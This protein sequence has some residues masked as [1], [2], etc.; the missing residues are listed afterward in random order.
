M[1]MQKRKM[2]KK[3]TD[4]GEDED[5]DTKMGGGLDIAALEAEAAAQ[6]TQDHGSRATM[7]DRAAR[8]EKARAEER[9]RKQER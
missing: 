2:R 8:A 7:V 6:G 1:C 3:E 4:T 5:G 9:Q